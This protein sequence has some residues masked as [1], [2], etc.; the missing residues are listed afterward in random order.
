MKSQQLLYFYYMNFDSPLF[1]LAG[2]IGPVFLLVG[3]IM[4]KL[5]PNKINGLYGYRTNQSM[6]SQQKWEFA[7]KYSAKLFIRYGVIQLLAGFIGLIITLEGYVAALIAVILLLANIIL[8]FY[9]TEQ[10]MKKLTLR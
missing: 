6:S 4:L 10:G 9:K 2:V 3:F 5:P 7:Q 8:L 1:L